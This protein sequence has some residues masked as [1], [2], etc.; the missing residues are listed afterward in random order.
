[1]GPGFCSLTLLAVEC[2]R[3]VATH[4]NSPRNPYTPCV[5]SGTFR[6]LNMRV[7]FS[8]EHMFLESY[9]ELTAELQRIRGSGFTQ[10]FSTWLIIITDV[11]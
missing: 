1:M 6:G 4:I 3:L 10:Y 5:S 11:L 7:K 9:L 8:Q 2:C